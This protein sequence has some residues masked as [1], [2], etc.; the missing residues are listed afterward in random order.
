M[1]WWFAH[2]PF[3]PGYIFENAPLLGD[4]RDKLLEGRHYVCEH[5]GDPIFV[6]AASVGSYAHQPRWIWTSL[7]PL[8]TLV[9]SFFALPPSFYQKVNDI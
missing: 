5:L 2:Q 8:S 3:P 7:T 6:D 1:L 4:S 9:A